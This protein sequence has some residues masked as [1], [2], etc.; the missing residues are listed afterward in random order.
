MDPE[1]KRWIGTIEDGL[2]T[3]NRTPHDPVTLD[4]SAY[5]NI[6]QSSELPSQKL[7]E[8]TEPLPMG[9]GPD[10]ETLFTRSNSSEG[11]LYVISNSKWPEWIKIG[12]TRDLHK[13]RSSYNTG[14]PISSDYYRYEY[15]RF[16]TNAR[17][18]EQKIHS[19]MVQMN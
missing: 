7:E 3:V 19:K 13:R 14:V 12:I 11:W 4:V 15:Y 10:G 8:I 5:Y 9:L 1:R 16:D 6:H 2:L 18:I 17:T